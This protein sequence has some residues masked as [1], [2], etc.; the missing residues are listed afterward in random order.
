[1]V[2]ALGP[3]PILSLAD[4]IKRTGG[5]VRVNAIASAEITSADLLSSGTGAAN[6]NMRFDLKRAPQTQEP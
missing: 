4:R 3:A 1:M 6:Q 2:G 5:F